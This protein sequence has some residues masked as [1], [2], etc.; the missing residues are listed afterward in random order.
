MLIILDSEIRLQ[1]DTQYI[2]TQICHL[3]DLFMILVMLH[4]HRT[5]VN[6]LAQCQVFFLI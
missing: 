3:Q 5:N 2:A 4:I 1:L 6:V